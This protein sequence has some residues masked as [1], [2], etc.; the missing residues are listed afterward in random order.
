MHDV[1]LKLINKSVQPNT[2][3][4]PW[5]PDPSNPANPNT[6]G[7]GVN[8]RDNVEQV[9]IPNPIADHEY[10]LTI[11]N[12]G[13]RTSPGGTHS[14]WVSVIMSGLKYTGPPELTILAMNIQYNY[15]MFTITFQTVM[16]GYYQLQY[17]YS[18]A[19]PW[20]TVA[21]VIRATGNSASATFYPPSPPVDIRAVAVSPNPFNVP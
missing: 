1:N 3:A 8:Y 5:N 18:P 6:G 10:E 19:G 14:Q 4:L 21:G 13:W 11:G 2:I 20:T 17:R 15:T 16:G 7:P 9:I 12:S